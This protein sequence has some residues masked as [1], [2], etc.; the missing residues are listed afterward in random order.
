MTSQSISVAD[1]LNEFCKAD[2]SAFSSPDLFR[3]LLAHTGSFHGRW[4]VHDKDAICKQI[5]EQFDIVCPVRRKSISTLFS[6]EQGFYFFDMELLK[7]LL[8]DEQAI[9]ITTFIGKRELPL[10]N[11]YRVDKDGLAE[12]MRRG[13]RQCYLRSTWESMSQA[14]SIL[15]TQSGVAWFVD[16]HFRPWE[17]HS[18]GKIRYENLERLTEMLQRI[19]SFSSLIL[20]CTKDHKTGTIDCDS[21]EPLLRKLKKRDNFRISLFLDLGDNRSFDT[22][23]RY[24]VT[25]N[26]AIF[27]EYGLA[28]TSYK[29]GRKLSQMGYVSHETFEQIYPTYSKCSPASRDSR[30]KLLCK[31]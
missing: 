10:P 3:L 28:T 15:A 26:G 31:V 11:V 16:T 9:E 6:P 22:H 2:V 8:S 24:F 5:Y 20:I 4:L 27:L 12:F 21:L 23:V 18:Q 30:F 19:P 14:V 17:N 29:G 25:R 13:P 1:A 7:N